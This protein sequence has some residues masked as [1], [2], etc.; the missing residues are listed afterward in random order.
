MFGSKPVM[1][2][3]NYFIPVGIVLPDLGDPTGESAGAGEA[4]ENRQGKD[5]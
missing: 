3:V 2:V 4:A 5:F 1:I